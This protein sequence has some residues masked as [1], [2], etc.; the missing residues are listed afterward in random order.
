MSRLWLE[1]PTISFIIATKGRPTLRALISTLRA[2]I[3]QQDEVL[4]IGDGPVPL[5]RDLCGFADERFKYHEYGPTGCFGN[6]QR[7]Y[8]MYHA[9]KQ[10]LMFAD[11]DD[12]YMPGVL[13]GAVREALATGLDRPHAFRR[14]DGGSEREGPPVPDIK[15]AWTV[16]GAMFVPPNIPGKLGTWN[17]TRGEQDAY[18]ILDT[19]AHYRDIGMLGHNIALYKVRPRGSS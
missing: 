1:A 5:A 13:C 14:R 18:F 9:S 4:V 16:G 19:M 12:D 11:D 8:G 7:D 2:E 17:A 10:F 15:S 3:G 6:H